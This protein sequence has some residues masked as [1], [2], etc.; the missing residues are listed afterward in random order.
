MRCERDEYMLVHEVSEFGI[1]PPDCST[2]ML[3]QDALGND[4]RSNLVHRQLP[5]S[6]HHPSNRSWSRNFIRHGQGFRN[7]RN[8][9]QTWRL[10]HL[11]PKSIQLKELVTHFCLEPTAVS[12]SAVENRPIVNCQQ[13][14]CAW[15]GPLCSQGSRHSQY[16]WTC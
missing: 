7:V 5:H 4:G 9:S 15:C 12:S 16:C 2:T 14:A 11:T 3:C 6:V 10:Q 8:V 1:G 13:P